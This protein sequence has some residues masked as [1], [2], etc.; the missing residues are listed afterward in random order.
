MSN[1]PFASTLTHFPPN[2]KVYIFGNLS[3]GDIKHPQRL[4]SVVNCCEIIA[5]FRTPFAV[6]TFILATDQ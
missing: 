3:N 2:N 6:R 5:A 4:V 1:A